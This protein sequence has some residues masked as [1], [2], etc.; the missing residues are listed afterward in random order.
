VADESGLWLFELLRLRVK[1]V[2]VSKDAP[3]FLINARRD[4]ERTVPFNQSEL[5]EISSGT[6]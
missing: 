2:D 5:P 3:S 1:D 6:S 4:H